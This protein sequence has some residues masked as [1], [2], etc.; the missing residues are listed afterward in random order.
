MTIGRLAKMCEVNASTVSR[1]CVSLGYGGYKDFQLDLAASL[2]HEDS[3]TLD[4]FDESAPPDIIYRRVFECNRHSLAETAR[5]ID[6]D[7]LVRVAQAIESSK[8]ALFLGIG[9]SGLVASEAAQRFTSLGILASAVTDP[10]QQIFVTG[11]VDKS[12][13]V[14]GISHTGRT[15]VVI[16]AVQEANRRKAKTVAL[17]NYPQS[18][19][20]VASQYQLITAFREHR[21][22]AAVSSS[23][24]AQMCII[25][26]LYFIVASRCSEGARRLADAAEERVQKLL[27]GKKT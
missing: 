12:N 21:I 26:A 20:A 22:N 18:P 24:I 11:S 4:D 23:R 7:A 17:T 10:Y 15:A 6:K 13:V 1:F 9:G 2:A 19:L 16:E 25:D 8:A 3:V 14:M 27:R 5:L